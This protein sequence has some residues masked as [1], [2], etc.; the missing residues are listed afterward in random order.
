MIISMVIANPPDKEQR[1]CSFFNLSLK[2]KFCRHGQ[3]HPYLINQ[4]QI[5][6]L[7]RRTQQLHGERAFNKSVLINMGKLWIIK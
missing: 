1:V 6:P 2:H 3:A 7:H 5:A 4:L